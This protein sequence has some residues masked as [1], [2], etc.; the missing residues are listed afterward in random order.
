MTLIY[1]FHN[2][3]IYAHAYIEIVENPEIYNTCIQYYHVI[4]AN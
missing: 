1:L 3:V 4:H 2:N